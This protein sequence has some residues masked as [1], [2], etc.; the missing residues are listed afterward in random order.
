MPAFRSRVWD[1][2]IRFYNQR[3]NQLPV[4]LYY[5]FLSSV[6]REIISFIRNQAIMVF[7][8]KL[9]KLTLKEV[10]DM[11]KV[12]ICLGLFAI[13]SSMQSALQSTEN[14][15]SSYLQL[16]PANLSLYTR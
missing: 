14:E 7:Q 8:K 1:G 4:G 6:S 15:Q 2:K 11:F 13:I 9:I 3:T 12:L 5:H 10:M 16:D